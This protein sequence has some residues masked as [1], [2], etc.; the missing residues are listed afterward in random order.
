MLKQFKP[1]ANQPSSRLLLVTLALIG[2]LVIYTADA[3][4]PVATSGGK[5]LFAPDANQKVS[6]DVQNSPIQ[7]KGGVSGNLSRPT[8]SSETYSTAKLNV[9]RT[10]DDGW[11]A[12]YYR[13][14]QEHRVRPKLIRAKVRRLVQ[15]NPQDLEQAI[16]LIRASLRAGQV[17]PWMYEALA[18]AMQMN[19]M[20]APEV[21]RV[22]MSS[23]DFAT[24]PHQLVFLADYMGR[25]GNHTRALDLL[26]EAALRARGLPEAYAKA[27]ALAVYLQDD[28]AIKWASLGILGQEWQKEESD[29]TA[30]ARRNAEALLVRLREENKNEEA[31]QFAKQLK[32]ALQ[33]D[34][35][36]KV[37]WS[38]DADVD[39]MVEDP[40]GS[41]CSYRQPRT[42]GGGV[43]MGNPNDTLEQSA[44]AGYAEA[45]CCPEAFAGDYRILLRQV[46]GKI[47]AGR[48]TVMSGIIPVQNK[49]F[50]FDKSF[51]ST[52]MG[53]L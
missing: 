31:D 52:K 20:P 41:I 35:V 7:T 47:P 5:S 37:S 1:C 50:I 19:N 2:F 6:T 18:L 53:P 27:L 32:E 39:L 48:V 45:Y 51:L 25:L 44:G 16:S 12:A 22:L 34:V 9:K 49:K 43:L 4:P 8:A 36:V 33:R 3:N 14:L 13:F 40:T 21:E 10:A 29:V 28:G 23:A 17:Q 15:G 42:A 26:R 11:E 24:T 38:G 46:W 30:K